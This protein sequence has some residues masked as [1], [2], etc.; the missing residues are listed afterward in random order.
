MPDHRDQL[1]MAAGLRPQDTEAVVSV[2]ERDAL[3]E[4]G[5]D[6]AV[7]RLGLLARLGVLQGDPP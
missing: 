2:V 3:D 5:E 7:R 1:A 4:A 6:F